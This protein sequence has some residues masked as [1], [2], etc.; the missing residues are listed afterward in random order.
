MANINH[1][2]N[3]LET[4]H[5]YATISTIVAKISCNLFCRKQLYEGPFTGVLMGYLTKPYVSRG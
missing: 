3:K 1:C 2:S 4:A 5:L